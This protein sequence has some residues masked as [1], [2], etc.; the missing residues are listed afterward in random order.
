M[1]H[2][3]NYGTNYSRTPLIW[4]DWSGEPSRYAENLDN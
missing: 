4:I 3:R 1:S 2:T